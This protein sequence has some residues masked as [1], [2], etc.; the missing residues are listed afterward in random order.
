MEK[1]F[2]SLILLISLT[3]SA[4]KK[5]KISASD[6]LQKEL[7]KELHRERLLFR[8]E[9]GVEG[10]LPEPI[11]VEGLRKSAIHRA[12][13]ISHFTSDKIW[14]M[15]KIVENGVFI[16]HQ[17]NETFKDFI[18][19]KNKSDRANYFNLTTDKGKEV[20]NTQEVLAAIFIESGTKAKEIASYAISEFKDSFKDEPYHW[21]ALMSGSTEPSDF[22]VSH[23]DQIGIGVSVF[24]FNDSEFPR[25]FVTIEIGYYGN[26]NLHGN[27]VK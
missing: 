3:T 10:F 7:V 24:Y 21:S 2:L 12:Q 18:S 13:Y 9:H 26:Y 23:E 20:K 11:F 4:Q 14:E 22:L 16:L 25:A 17:E 19:L 5:F 6:D 15:C 27:K 8:K 1:L